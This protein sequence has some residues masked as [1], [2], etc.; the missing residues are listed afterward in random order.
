MKTPR[1]HLLAPFFSMVLVTGC[2]SAPD[3]VPAAPA[4]PTNLAVEPRAGAGH[5]T[6]IDNSDDEIHFMV[7]RKEQAATKY[8]VIAT[9]PIDTV[10]YH[11]AAVTSGTTYVYQIMSMNDVG[12]S[13]SNEVAFTAP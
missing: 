11:D 10:V 9:V 2:L 6:W 3:A 5:V 13:T 7:M 12:E 1:G 4:A 8:E